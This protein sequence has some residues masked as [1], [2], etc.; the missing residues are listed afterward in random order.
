MVRW[1]LHCSAW[2]PCKKDWCAAMA[3]VQAEERDRIS[4]FVFQRDAKMALV[5][6]WQ[7]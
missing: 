3:S 1:F 5:S 2:L 6:K 7:R 4:K